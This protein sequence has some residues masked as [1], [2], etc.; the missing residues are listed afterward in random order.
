MDATMAQSRKPGW[1]YPYIFLGAFVVV[2]GVN[3]TLAYF[4]TS[5]FTG[6]ST[7]NAYEKGLAYNQNLAMAEAQARLGWDVSFT[8]SPQAD[9]AVLLS[10]SYRDRDGRP[11]N[12]LDVRANLL[13]PTVKGHD[14]EVT[15][16]AGGDG[17]Y[18]LKHRTP[19][20]GVWDAEVVAIG[21]GVSYQLAKR[22]VVP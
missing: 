18:T 22:I 16:E 10:V 4:A 19:L 6:L 9:G 2:L 13:R 11:V 14:H 20:A 15:L 1:W 7:D 5:T 21:D 3:V 17:L 8:A 12:G